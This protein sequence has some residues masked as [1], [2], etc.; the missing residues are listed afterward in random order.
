MLAQLTGLLISFIQ[1]TGYFGVFFL[2]ALG[3]ALIPIPS[4]ITLPFAGFL[5][6]KG[7][8]VFPL[9]VLVAA[10]GDLAGSLIGYSIGF[11]LEETVIVNLIKKHGKYVLLS[12]H[13]YYKASAWFNKYGDKLVFI[14]KLLP[15][16]RYMISIPA[17]AVKMD[18]R[19]F[20][21]YTFLGSLIW[22]TLMVYVGVYFGDRW[23][24]LE[25]IFNQ[26]KIVIIVG[27]VLAVAWYVNHKLHLF[28]R[29]KS[30]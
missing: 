17:G 13:D 25:P 15:G 5:I 26:F 27:L 4:E 19:K 14:G 22:C 23:D 29:K 8:F 20:A 6:T 21:L 1:S 24:S 12:H 16:L 28:P 30:N 7:T 11:F 9:V 3:S 10:L 2:M 18:L